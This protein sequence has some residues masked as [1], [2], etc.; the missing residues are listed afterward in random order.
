MVLREMAERTREDGEKKSILMVFPA[1]DNIRI[2]I[3]RAEPE[4]FSS[5]TIVEIPTD[6]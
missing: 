6:G 1:G 5:G 2:D 4:E 3:S